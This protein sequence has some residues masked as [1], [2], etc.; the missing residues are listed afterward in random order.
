MIFW[1]SFPVAENSYSWFKTGEIIKTLSLDPLTV[2]LI[3]PTEAFFY[4]NFVTLVLFN[5]RLKV[6]SD[7]LRLGLTKKKDKKRLGLTPLF[8][9][10]EDLERLGLQLLA[11]SNRSVNFNRHSGIQ[12]VSGYMLRC[13]RRLSK[14]GVLKNSR[15]RFLKSPGIL[16]SS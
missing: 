2:S 14:P 3:V 12:C 9:G 10:N 4:H 16:E 13:Q 8:S 15:F 7:H 6:F 11:N 5:L 1:E